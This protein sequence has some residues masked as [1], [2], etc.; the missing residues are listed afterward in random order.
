MLPAIT[1]FSSAALRDTLH[2]ANLFGCFRSAK[3]CPPVL[4]RHTYPARRCTYSLNPPTKKCGVRLNPPAPFD[5]GSSSAAGTINLIREAH[6]RFKGIS[7]TE[8]QSEVAKIEPLKKLVEE[9]RTSALAAL[10][11]ATQLAESEGKTPLAIMDAKG[12]TV[13]GRQINNMADAA[14]V[15]LNG[16]QALLQQMLGAHQANLAK[17][18]APVRLGPAPLKATVL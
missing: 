3:P 18:N 13:D 2:R 5:P 4:T 6:M 14:I 7:V 15:G 16:L 10:A 11:H 1:T 8:L 17:A 12:H 9:E